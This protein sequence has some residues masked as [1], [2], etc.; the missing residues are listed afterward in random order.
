MHE[1]FKRVDMESLFGHS[2]DIDKLNE[3]R[4]GGL[5]DAMSDFGPNDLLSKVSVAAFKRYG[6]KLTNVNF[7]T[8]SK[9]MW[10]EYKTENG[11]SES[12]Q[13]AFGYSK[14]KRFDKKQMMLS[15]GTTQNV[16]IDGLVLSGNTSDKRYNI[17]NLDRAQIIRE[18]FEAA[19]EDFFYI[20]D[21][22]AFTLEFLKKAKIMSIHVITR[23]PDNVLET[24]TA[25]EKVTNALESLP[26]IAIENAKGT[27]DYKVMSS[28]CDYHGIPIKIA[29]CYSS[30]LE[31]Q[32]R[33]TIFKKVVKEHDEIKL[34]LSRLEK[35]E[36]KTQSSVERKFQFMK[37]PQFINSFYLNSL[38][39]I[40]A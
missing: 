26:I 38:S 3:D 18:K 29:S 23:M 2:V 27:A 1:Y 16:C 30:S 21:S 5:L 22:A 34:A 25:I 39:R 17:D 36:Y 28:T 14:Q 35:R 7:D 19:A 37:S 13:I 9:I 24:K 32:K 31:T 20:A 33:T 11:D 6:I 4:F 8:T 12:F 10:G 15:L 40:E